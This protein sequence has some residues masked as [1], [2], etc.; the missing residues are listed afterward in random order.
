[1]NALVAM[2][3]KTAQLENSLRAET[4]L[5]LDL[6]SALGDARRQ[7]EIAASKFQVMFNLEAR[8]LR[9]NQITLAVFKLDLCNKFA[10]VYFLI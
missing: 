9:V 4:K 1:M 10:V 6:F 8:F 2:Q 7:V 5:K 3:D